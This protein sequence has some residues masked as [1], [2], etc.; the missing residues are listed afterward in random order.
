[1]FVLVE[2]G[3]QLEALLDDCLAHAHL[4]FVLPLDVLLEVVEV[5]YV[6]LVVFSALRPLDDLFGHAGD[7][8]KVDN[9]LAGDDVPQQRQPLFYDDDVDDLLGDDGQ[10]L[11]QQAA[12][13]SRLQRCSREGKE[14]LQELL[15]EN[16]CDIALHRPWPILAA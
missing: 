15:I 12:V 7:H 5:V 1:M 9:L 8:G 2:E 4:A 10:Q 3:G 16:R 11:H 14:E 13:H 6:F